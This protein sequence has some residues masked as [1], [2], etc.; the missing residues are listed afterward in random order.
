LVS[1]NDWKGIFEYFYTLINGEWVNVASFVSWPRM[2]YIEGGQGCDD[3][4]T[5][6]Y[7][8]NDEEVS[9]EEFNAARDVYYGGIEEYKKERYQI[10][11][12][13]IL[14]DYDNIGFFE[15]KAAEAENM[16]NTLL[17]LSQNPPLTGDNKPAVPYAAFTLSAVIIVVIMRIKGIKDKPLGLRPKP[18]RCA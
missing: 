18:R 2:F 11:G 12:K 7:L 5:P 13:D 16:M 4:Y 10:T 8:I 3:P 14:G 9:R 1:K 15:K 6:G 17:K